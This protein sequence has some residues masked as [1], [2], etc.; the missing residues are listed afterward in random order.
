MH[1]LLVCL[2]SLAACYCTNPLGIAQGI[3]KLSVK[4]AFIEGAIYGG[5]RLPGKLQKLGPEEGFLEES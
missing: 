4:E 3:P 2:A 5:A 1:L